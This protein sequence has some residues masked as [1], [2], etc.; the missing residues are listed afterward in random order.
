MRSKR[1]VIRCCKKEIGL[2]VAVGV[3]VAVEVGCFSV[4]GVEDAEAVDRG[5]AVDAVTEAVGVVYDEVRVGVGVERASAT[6]LARGV[7]TNWGVTIRT[8]VAVGTGMGV[9]AATT[10]M[11]GMGR[12]RIEWTVRVEKR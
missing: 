10:K 3:A 9:Q 6:T 11:A 4:A 7:V 5:S 1:F 2:G 8:V 12:R